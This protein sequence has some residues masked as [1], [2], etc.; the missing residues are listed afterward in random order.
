MN[1][2]ASHRTGTKLAPRYVEAVRH[3]YASQGR[4]AASRLL[5]SAVTTLDKVAAG[6]GVTPAA[7]A[8]IM[9]AIDAWMGGAA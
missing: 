9:A 1:A 3:L 7:A 8:R 2:G 5:K 6:A 4:E